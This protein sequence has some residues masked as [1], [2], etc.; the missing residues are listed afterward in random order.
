ME[1]DNN[2]CAFCGF[3]LTSD[4]RGGKPQSWWPCCKDHENASTYPQIWLLKKELKMAYEE[5]T[6]EERICAVCGI[7]LTE[8]EMSLVEK[9]HVNFV[10]RFHKRNANDAQIQLTRS[11]KG[12]GEYLRRPIDEII[13]IWNL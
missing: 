2:H 5:P 1:K 9:T 3:E 11:K 13:K 8:E 12:Y 7:D 6:Q 4:N 10:C